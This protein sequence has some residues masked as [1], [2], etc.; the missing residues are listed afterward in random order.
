MVDSKLIQDFFEL[1][2]KNNVNY[3]LIKNDG[4]KLPYHLESGKD[5]DFLIHPDEYHR[6]IDIVTENG[7]EKKVGESCKRYFLYQ[8]KEDI[9][10]KKED[11]YFHFFEALSCNP[12]TN[13]GKCKMPLETSVQNYIW[14]HKKWDEI[15]DWWIMDDISIL[16]YLIVRSVFD[17]M[18]F[19]E[20][21]ISEIE[22]RLHFIDSEDFYDLA[23]TVFYSF[24]PRMIELI[25]LG[26]YERILNEYLSYRD[27]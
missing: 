23:K 13:M 25:K 20:I 22:K 7:Y 11:C 26:K 2:N 9:F 8:L 4:D 6:L 12:L 24:T 16:L 1:L 21:Y 19:R 10:L 18:Q 17:K 15:H 3:V 5:I 14:K 27:Y